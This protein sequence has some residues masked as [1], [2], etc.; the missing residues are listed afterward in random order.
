MGTRQDLVSVIVP[1]YNMEQHLD[2]CLSGIL[3]QT[4]EDAY[5]PSAHGTKA[6]Q[7]Q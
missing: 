5:S 6:A 4:Y 2:L 3:R 1:I 7:R